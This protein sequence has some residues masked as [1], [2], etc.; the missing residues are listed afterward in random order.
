[1]INEHKRTTNLLVYCVITLFF[2]L[3][4]GFFFWV[5]PYHLYL[6]EQLTLFVMHSDY[7][8]AYLYK[9]AFLAE[10]A[11]DYLTQFYLLIGGGATILTLMMALFW[12]G[13][14]SVL[15]RLNIDRHA[16]L[17]ALLPVIAEWALSCHIEYPLSMV[18]A[19]TIAVWSSVAYTAIKK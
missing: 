15:K 18:I 11:G 8:T 17:W 12:W 19:I 2:I 7:I 6:K 13:I 9:P 5:Y 10:M 16:G 14:R 1:M 4:W 3:C